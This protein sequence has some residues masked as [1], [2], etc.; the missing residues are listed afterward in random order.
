VVNTASNPV[1]VQPV[2]A[3]Q[4]VPLACVA[5]FDS[6]SDSGQCTFFDSTFNTY[7]VPAGKRLVIDSESGSCNVPAGQRV[8]DPSINLNV[9]N[10]A[11]FF[12]SF[13]GFSQNY[14][15]SRSGGAGTNDLYHLAGDGLA[16]VDPGKT[17]SFGA[18]RNATDGEG[19]CAINVQAHLEDIQ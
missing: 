11:G 15:G 2:P 8:Q 3:R 10:A 1:A 7:T 13:V 19:S 16:Y 18:G 14:E 4:A 5:N 9:L 17:L 6:G 12:S